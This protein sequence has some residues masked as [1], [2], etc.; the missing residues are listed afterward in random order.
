MN[1]LEK[2]FP[3]RFDD[4]KQLLANEAVQHVNS[5][6]RSLVNVRKLKKY[7][8]AEVAKE[9]GISREAVAQFE[10]HDSNPTL[11]TIKRYAIAVGARID[12]RVTDGSDY[13]EH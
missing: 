6:V 13:D 8:Q 1:F 9:L 12:I 5:L 7:T 4:P 2:L 3:D 10:R 11:N